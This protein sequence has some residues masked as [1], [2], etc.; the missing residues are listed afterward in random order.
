MFDN[1]PYRGYNIN[2]ELPVLADG[3]TRFNKGKIELRSTDR[4]SVREIGG[5][6]FTTV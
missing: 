5:L 1:T 6:F 3:Y 4:L 2:K